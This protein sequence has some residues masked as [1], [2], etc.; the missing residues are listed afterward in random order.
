MVYLLTVF[1]LFSW[2]KSVFARQSDPDMITNTALETIASLSSKT[3]TY[4]ANGLK[5]C[6]IELFYLMTSVVILNNG[7]LAN[8]SKKMADEVI[9]HLQLAI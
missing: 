9:K 6:I 5:K 7:Q 2:L 1:E 3:V 8:D 4:F